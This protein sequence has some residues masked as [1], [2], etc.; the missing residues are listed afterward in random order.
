MAQRSSA[1][2]F[3]FEYLFKLITA[4]SGLRL[5]PFV[6]LATLPARIALGN[7]FDPPPPSP[8]IATPSG[9]IEVATLSEQDV[10]PEL[11]ACLKKKALGFCLEQELQ[12]SKDA[13]KNSMT[14]DPTDKNL[15]PTW[16]DFSKRILRISKESLERGKLVSAFGFRMGLA[17][18]E[19]DEIA[20]DPAKLHTEKTSAKP[21][22]WMR[23]EIALIPQMVFGKY[24][25]RNEMFGGLFGLH[26]LLRM[27]KR[28]DI[29]P[30]LGPISR[31]KPLLKNVIPTYL[32]IPARLEGSGLQPGESIEVERYGNFEFAIGPS[33]DFIPT[34]IYTYFQ[35]GLFAQAGFVASIVKGHFRTIV[36]AQPD[37]T[38]HVSLE[39]INQDTEKLQAQA[40]AGFK[41]SPINFAISLANIEAGVIH[42]RENILDMS[43]D[44][45]YPEAAQALKKAYLGS[46]GLAQT[47]ASQANSDYRGVRLLQHSKVKQKTHEW[48]MSFL[49]LEA[50][51]SVS[52]LRIDSVRGDELD[53]IV[54]ESADHDRKTFFKKQDLDIHFRNDDLNGDDPSNP[55]ARS[56]SLKYHFK[57]SR[58][59][60]ADVR[61]LQDIARVLSPAERRLEPSDSIPAIQK[62]SKLSGYLYLSFDSVNVNALFDSADLETRIRSA[63]AKIVHLPDP[64]SWAY[65]PEKQQ[66]ELAAELPN[67]KARFK[68]LKNFLKALRKSLNE[69][70]V[71]KQSAR[72]AKTLRTDGFDLYPIAALAM[73]SDPNHLLAYEQAFLQSGN[74]IKP[75]VLESIGSSY[76]SSVHIHY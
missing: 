6:L 42:T 4:S 54:I 34:P 37:H 7:G 21:G 25:P 30:A 43:F 33:W 40:S 2:A 17:P 66:K 64:E 27:V 8:P 29:D 35:A 45:T 59:K 38:L 63:W 44:T 13:Q 9:D 41:L 74:D 3:L 46:F 20:E 71:V 31:L 76:S 19:Y 53:Q 11:K 36:E 75:I 32:S 24:L 14:K 62:K 47:L 26:G 61:E 28:L 16:H 67:G 23:H 72:L 5:L 70:D 58:A 56:F 73:I 10:S 12:E 57:N 68:H 65:L 52:D 51:S 22:L 18:L 39:R 1:L 48:Q 15:S 55:D 60:L 49:G 69:T 50:G